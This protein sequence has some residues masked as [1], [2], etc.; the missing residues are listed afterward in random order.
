[1]VVFVL[2]RKEEVA[3][4]EELLAKLENFPLR[5]PLLAILLLQNFL[6]THELTIYH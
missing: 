1:M 2:E 3:S 5:L 4:L 6:V